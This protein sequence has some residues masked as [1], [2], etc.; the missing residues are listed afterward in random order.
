MKKPITYIILI[1]LLISLFSIGCGKTSQSAQTEP[2]SSTQNSKVDTSSEKSPVNSDNLG[3]KLS[4]VYADMMKNKKYFMQ[5]KINSVFDGESMEIEATLAVS[6]ENTA[7]TS[8]MEGM[9]TTIISK[10]E[11]TYMVNHSD[12]IVMEIPQG[13]SLE[14]SKDNKIETDGLTYISNGV[15]DGLTY[16]KYSTTDGVMKYYFNG[17][18]LLKIV[19]ENEEQTMVMNIIEISNNVLDSMFEIPMDYQTL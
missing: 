19:F 6:G 17:K 10:G 4:T 2:S 12:K 7:V 13:S 1:S 9:K 8:I 18:K 15:E 3:A 14:N 16:E 5:Y 11:K